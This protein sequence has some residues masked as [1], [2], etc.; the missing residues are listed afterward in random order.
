VEIETVKK[1]IATTIIIVN[2]LIMTN[3]STQIFVAALVVLAA[4]LGYNYFVQPFANLNKAS[5]E[6]SQSEVD[7]QSVDDYV[8]KRLK[9]L[10]E[11]TPKQ[12]ISQLIAYPYVIEGTESGQ[13]MDEFVENSLSKNATNSASLSSLE[14]G[15][16]TIFGS[17]I[18]FENAANHLNYINELFQDKSLSPLI[19]VDHEGGS[20]QRLSGYGFTHLPPWE[21][22]C[23]LNQFDL[24]QQLLSSAKELSD[25]GVNIVFAPVLDIDSK[26][27]G[28]RS[29][30][31]YD[32]LLLTSIEYIQ[33]FG[34]QQILSVVKHFPGLGNTKKDLHYY[35]DTI[36]VGVDDTLIFSKIFDVFP[37]IGVMSSHIKIKDKL[38]GKPCSM[39]E[40]CLSVFNQEMPL[41]LVFTDALEMKSLDGFSVEL[42]KEFDYK[43]TD[44]SEEKSLNKIQLTP[45]SRLAA[46]SY[47]AIMAG[48]N[49][50]VFGAGVEADQLLAVVD[51]LSIHYEQNE[52]FV[53]KVDNSLLKI[54][55]VKQINH[56]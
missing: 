26:V 5:I 1:R 34:N 35:S 33:I 2:K 43:K 56:D 51:E 44:N 6:E 42:A 9:L 29:C 12:K 27:L 22:L 24:K 23:D 41:I 52:E 39:S 36:E 19:A 4:L 14:P 53:K 31:D 20:V 10:E 37:N 16:I 46:L 48:N 49:V 32:S 40:E 3:R 25:L 13:L 17:E 18:S 15:I 54:L 21:E 30:G 47:Q 45:E 7:Q 38:D 8:D 50:L 55:A 11:L 28:D